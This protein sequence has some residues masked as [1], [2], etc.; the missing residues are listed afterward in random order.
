[1]PLPSRRQILAASTLLLTAAPQ[2]GRAEDYPSRA[3]TVV[4][5]YP[6][7]GI[8]DTATRLIAQRMEREL[9]HPVVVEN[10]SGA[11]T[12]IASTYVVQSAP[13]GYTLLMG[14][15]TLAINPTLQPNLEPKD[16]QKALAPV[17]MGY[18][19][20]FVLHVHRDLPVH[21]VAE[22]I[23]YAKANPGKLNFG[24]SGNGAVNHLA[25]ARFNNATGTDLQHVP[26]RGGA[27]ALIDLRTGRIQGMFSAVLE[28]L[29]A[30]REGVTRAL[31]VSSAE[32]VALLPEV[33]AVAETVPGFEAVYWQALF[34]PAGTPQPVLDRLGAALRTATEDP[35]L[36]ARLAEQGVTLQSGDAAFLRGFLARETES[37]GKVIQA[38]HIRME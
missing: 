34:A 25:L 9:G 11:A 14:A 4:V 32:R 26:Y 7:G 23:A 31:G 22:L 36:R 5:G 8:S 12:A 21:S 27:P 13:D 37:W 24:S 38:A 29:P 17:G 30:I 10:R 20:A 15:T 3:V 18:Q 28:A 6:P 19:S 33:P 2:T 1:M 35:D 16:P